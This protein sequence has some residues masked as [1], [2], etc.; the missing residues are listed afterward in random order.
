MTRTLLQWDIYEV[1]ATESALNHISLRGRLR[2][3]GLEKTLDILVENTEDEP[4]RLRFAV[5]HDTQIDSIQDYL[6]GIIP[7]AATTLV[8]KDVSN[9]VLSKLRIN[10]ETRYTL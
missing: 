4:G 1:A 3:L 9:P 10:D 8:L 5:L 2:K 6:Q 7:D